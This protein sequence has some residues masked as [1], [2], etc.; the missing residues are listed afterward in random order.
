MSIMTPSQQIPELVFA[1]AWQYPQELLEHG[2]S[3]IL[4]NA[5]AQRFLRMDTRAWAR[6]YFGRSLIDYT[7][8]I[9]HYDYV[10]EHR[11]NGDT[12]T[13]FIHPMWS[14]AE[15]G[16]DTLVPLLRGEW[17]GHV[18]EDEEGNAFNIEPL[19]GQTEYKVFVTDIPKGY[20]VAT[21]YLAKFLRDARVRGLIVPPIY[22]DSVEALETGLN[23][24]A[25]GVVYNASYPARYGGIITCQGKRIRLENP[26]K[27]RQ[28]RAAIEAVG[29]TVEDILD[30]DKDTHLRFNIASARFAAN[31]WHEDVMPI[32]PKAQA[33][34]ANQATA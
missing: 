13:E 22:F 1:A 6:M 29:Y 24:G 27:V 4:I 20:S 11:V 9:R 14:H 28:A 30:G 2:E 33:D 5:E 15:R 23:F 10:E 26:A 25:D 3:S 32:G 21:Q 31:H 18:A 8:Y 16:I 17:S 12:V 19:R 7:L 34:A